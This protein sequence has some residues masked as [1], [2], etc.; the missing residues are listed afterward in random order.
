MTKYVI[1]KYL[2]IFLQYY[3]E[4]IRKKIQFLLLLITACNIVAYL[5]PVVILGAIF[6]WAKS[7]LELRR[8]EGHAKAG[9]FE[10]QR[11]PISIMLIHM[12]LT[13][14]AGLLAIIVTSGYIVACENLH[15]FVR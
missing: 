6:L 1:F 5:F 12:C 11:V 15:G 14:L 13:A 7:W 2:H 9:K 10:D 8:R 3:H 4:H